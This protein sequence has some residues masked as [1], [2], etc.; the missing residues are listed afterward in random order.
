MSNGPAQTLKQ[1]R[2]RQRP[3]SRLLAELVRQGGFPVERPDSPPDALP[4]AP[5]N[6]AKFFWKKSCDF[7]VDILYP[8]RNIF[9]PLRKIGIIPRRNG[10]RGSV[11]TTRKEMS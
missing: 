3:S 10:L 5:A 2:S 11:P 8:R 9:V 7:F 1:P 4:V 6:S